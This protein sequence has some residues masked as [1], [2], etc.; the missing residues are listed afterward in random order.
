MSKDKPSALMAG[1][2]RHYILPRREATKALLRRAQEQGTVHADAD[3][4]V[5]VGVVTYRVRQPNPPDA[6]DM[7]RSRSSA[8]S[9]RPV[10]LAE[11]WAEAAVMRRGGG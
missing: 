8:P 7:R 10:D 1:S 11:C 5:L 2:W 4:D 6:I 3:L 9:G